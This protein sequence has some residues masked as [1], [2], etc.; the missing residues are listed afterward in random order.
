MGELLF[1]GMPIRQAPI[2]SGS[3]RRRP[4]GDGPSGRTW[5]ACVGVLM[6]VALT[7][8]ITADKRSAGL[9][10]RVTVV[11]SCSVN[12]D[13]GLQTGSTVTCGTRFAPPVMSATS[14]VTLPTAAPPPARIEAGAATGQSRAAV[15]EQ[16]G[17]STDALPGR[18]A[19]TSVI[20]AAG[21]DGL[22]GSSSTEADAV[23]RAVRLVT[24][25]F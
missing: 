5:A 18:V 14:V 11:R 23:P 15:D 6:L 19:E 10:V 2:R 13:T 9:A 7:R 24:V 22:T 25:N 20:R 1:H 16:N 3:R 17:R 8:P 12:T 4:F 21:S